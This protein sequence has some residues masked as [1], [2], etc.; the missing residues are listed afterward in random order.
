MH[1]SPHPETITPPTIDPGTPTTDMLIGAAIGTGTQAQVTSFESTVGQQIH[2]YRSYD[3]GFPATWQQGAASWHPDRFV[4]W[5]SLKPNVANTASGALDTQLETWVGSIPATHRCM[6][7][8]Q[9]EPENPSK[10]INPAQW[11]TAF[12]RFYDIVKGI[13]PDIQVGPILMGWTY[14]TASGRDPDGDWNPG[15]DKV[16]FYGIDDYQLYLL[17]GA[18]SPTSW[19]EAPRHTT[20][21]CTQLAASH[22]RPI[23]MGELACGDYQG[24]FTM[25]RDWIK[26]EVD[27]M[28]DNN[29]MAFCYF[30]TN[31]NN[32]LA[33]NSLITDDPLTQAYFAGLLSDPPQV[34]PWQ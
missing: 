17:E 24:D 10:G 23:A 32:D 26:A 16:D 15:A 30:N 28:V 11:R 1:F 13:R 19:D 29:A 9:H 18:G 27:Y 2:V 34:Q 12:R 22:D 7:T 31:T 33:P 20:I 14:D 4:S 8:F 6:L 3:S 5:H 21:R 25:K